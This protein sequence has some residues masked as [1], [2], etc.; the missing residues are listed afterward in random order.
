VIRFWGNNTTRLRILNFK[1]GLGKML[2]AILFTPFPKL[3]S[4]DG[5]GFLLGLADSGI[6]VMLQRG[7]DITDEI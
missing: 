1:F 5:M 6:S 3:A 7:C 2:K 4:I